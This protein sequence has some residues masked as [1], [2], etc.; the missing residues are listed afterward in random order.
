MRPARSSTLRCLETAGP[1]ILK[2]LESSETGELNA[3]RYKWHPERVPNGPLA[4]IVALTKQRVYVY[5]NGIQIGVS[6]S[7][8][9]KE[10]YETPTGIFTILEKEE[11][12]YLK[13]LT[14][15]RCRILSG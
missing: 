6:T 5:R 9:G 7:S 2:G 12:H 14:M 10:G 11:E 3:S 4:I 13:I 8:T 1:L 15:H